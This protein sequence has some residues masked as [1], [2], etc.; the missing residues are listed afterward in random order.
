M[1]FVFSDPETKLGRYSIPGV[2]LKAW[3]LA[4]LRKCDRFYTGELRVVP[5]GRDNIEPFR[6]VALLVGMLL[7]SKGG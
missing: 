3:A 7:D 5:Y 2:G 1:F 4:P 6:R